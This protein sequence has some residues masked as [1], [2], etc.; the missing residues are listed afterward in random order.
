MNT[1]YYDDC[2]NQ[3]I[4]EMIVA[5]AA[6]VICICFL[7]YFLHKAIKNRDTD[8]KIGISFVL[9][10]AIVGLTLCFTHW[11]RLSSDKRNE[12]YI[13]YSGDYEVISES[14]FR[15]SAVQIHLAEEGETITFEEGT[16]SSLYIGKHHG[17]IVYSERTK[18]IVDWHCDKEH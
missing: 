6:I 17:Y 1:K 4:T 7:I 9:V 16:S 5:F 14:G 15:L 18:V 8:G 3:K 11:I 13:V 10:L 2:L 12:S